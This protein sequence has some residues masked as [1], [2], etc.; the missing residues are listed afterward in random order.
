MFQRVAVSILLFIMVHGTVF[1]ALSQYKGIEMTIEIVEE[2]TNHSENTSKLNENSLEFLC[3]D[4]AWFFYF[5]V[6]KKFPYSEKFDYY[7][8]H[9][10][11]IP[12]K[13]LLDNPP[14]V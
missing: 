11:T 5:Q 3:Q 4:H 14:E 8:Q 9:Y 12:V 6:E 7:K 2:E 1:I 13:S 10:K